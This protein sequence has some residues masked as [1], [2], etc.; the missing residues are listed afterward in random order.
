MCDG[1]WVGDFEPAFL[2]V[3]AVIEYRT[4]DEERALWIDNQTDVRSWNE[5]V[6]LFGAIH[7][8]HRV[9]QTGAATAD[10]GQTQGAVW[11]S[12]LVQ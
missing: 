3:V 10:D 5:N 2:Q 8:I 7:Q 4:A 9:L 12:F 11:I 6:A 1:V